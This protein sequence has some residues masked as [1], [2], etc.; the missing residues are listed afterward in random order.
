MD[1]GDWNPGPQPCVANTSSIKPSPSLTLSRILNRLCFFPLI[2]SESGTGE[3]LKFYPFPHCP[4]PRFL[5]LNFCLLAPEGPVASACRWAHS[6]SSFYCIFLISETLCSCVRAASSPLP[7]PPTS[8]RSWEYLS[9]RLFWGLNGN[10]T[11]LVFCLLN[12]PICLNG[13]ICQ[14]SKSKNI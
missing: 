2:I 1:S 7:P 13:F 3:P 14:F 10:G 9:Y 5:W 4:F 11:P 12:Q 8:A 6:Q